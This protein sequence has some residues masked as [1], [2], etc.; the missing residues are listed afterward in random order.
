MTTFTKNL[1]IFTVAAALFFGFAVVAP[2]V[3]AGANGR[4]SAP[5]FWVSTTGTPLA[6]DVS[7]ATAAYST[8]QSAITAAE[9]TDSFKVPSIEVCPGTY[10]EQDVITGSVSISR[11]PVP[12]GLGPVVIQL[13]AAV[14][15]DQLL[16][17]ST[18]N[19][20]VGDAAVLPDAITPPQSVIEICSATAAGDNTRGVSV[21]ISDVTVQGNWP[22]NV[23]YGSLYD[24]L[25]GG[26]ASLALDNSTVEQAGAYPL[27]GCQGGVGIQVGL[28]PTN[29]IGHAILNDDVVNTYQKNGITIDGSGST[30]FISRTTVTGIGPTTQIAQNGIQISNGATGS[31]TGSAVSGNNYTG[32]GDA[33]SGGILVDGGCGAPLV[34]NTSITGNVLVNNDVGIYLFNLDPTCTIAPSTPTHDSASLNKI[35]NSNGYP[36]GVASA[37]ANVSGDGYPEGYQAGIFDTGNRDAITGNSISGAGY[38]PSLGTPSAPVLPA[39]VLP[40]DVVSYPPTNTLVKF[41]TYDGHPFNP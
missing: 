8:V 10:S 7:C 41:N 31:V 39:F 17:L 24:I 33:S 19:C 12:Q 30:A 29:Q 22:T 18:T 15:A 23:C 5:V 1:R 37:G 28:Y 6:S 40:I 38:A 32:N 14:G 26:G 9:A 11:A 13:P 35:T 21:S 27:N 20:Q 34:T 3:P 16:G 36:G 4:S 2:L 25:V